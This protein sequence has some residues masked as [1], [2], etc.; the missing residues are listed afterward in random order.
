MEYRNITK[1]LGG[2]KVIHKRIA[3]RLD[4]FE[5]GRKGIPKQSLTNLLRFMN[6]S[7]RQAEELLPVSERTIQ[8]KPSDSLLSSVVSESVI[9]ISEVVA[10]GIEVFENKEKFLLWLKQKNLALGGHIPMELLKSTFGAELVID[11]LGRMEYGV[12]S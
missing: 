2:E 1:I 6:I 5:L 4:L 12:L 3:K 8:R 9:K 11:E 10:K 7:L